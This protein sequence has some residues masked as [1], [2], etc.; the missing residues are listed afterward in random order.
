MN[1]E[2]PELR[3]ARLLDAL[4]N[5]HERARNAVNELTEVRGQLQQAVKDAAGESVSSALKALQGDIDRAGQTL[6]DLQGLS[7]W[8]AAW[9]HAMVAVVAILITLLGVWWYVPSLSEIASQRAEVATAEASL[10]DLNERGAR[11][12][13]SICGPKKRFCVRV[14]EKAGTFGNSAKDETYMIAKGY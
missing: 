4:D 7:L 1:T 6:V 13:R 9:Q 2:D 12:E 5:L 3:I 10:A 14:D 8:R 11:M